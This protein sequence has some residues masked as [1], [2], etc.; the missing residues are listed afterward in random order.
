MPETNSF[1]IVNPKVD[2]PEAMIFIYHPIKG[3]WIEIKKRKKR[4]ATGKIVISA[5]KRTRRCSI[6]PKLG[7]IKKV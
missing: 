6:L 7:G 4:R 2:I 1:I 3:T 5:R